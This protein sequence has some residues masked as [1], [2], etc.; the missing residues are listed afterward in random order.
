MLDGL[1]P[2]QNRVPIP[3]S[4]RHLVQLSPAI[5]WAVGPTPTFFVNGTQVLGAL[6]LPEWRK[7]IEQVRAGAG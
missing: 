2:M 1:A 5:G 3:A 7:L 4:A 6:P